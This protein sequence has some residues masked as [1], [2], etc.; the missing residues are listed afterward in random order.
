VPGDRTHAYAMADATSLQCPSC[1]APLPVEH[2]FVRMVAC[3]YCD[4]VS[5]L[6]D[7]GL[8]PT[9]KTARLAPL[10]TQFAVGQRGTLRGRAF[11]VLGRVRYAYDDGVW[12][13]WYLAFDDGDAAWLEEDEGQYV[14]SRQERLRT[15]PPPFESARVGTQFEVNG[16]TFHVTE[17]LRARIA[18][19]EG[20]LFY[21]AAPG[22]PVAFV[23]GNIGGRI[24]YLEY[25]EDSVEF[26]VGE[27]LPRAEIRVENPGA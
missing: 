6:T 21:R 8:D 23:E 27:Q 9:G 13:E 24:A 22:R 25:G 15:P 16:H 17:R 4:T 14:L 7:T 20:Q 1:G 18:G 26:G 19:A 5:E 3:R 12:D 2:R 10:P 11:T